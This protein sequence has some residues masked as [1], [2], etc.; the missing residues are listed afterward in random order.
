MGQT[1]SE[2][3]M[4]FPFEKIV[5][6]PTYVAISNCN[7]ICGTFG[8]ATAYFKRPVLEGSFYIES[9]FR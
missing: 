4:P 6:R 8:H 2:E 1:I 7:R 9:I 3:K 5:K